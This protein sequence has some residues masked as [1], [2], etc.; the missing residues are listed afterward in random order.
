VVAETEA[1]SEAV[2]VAEAVAATLLGDEAVQE[3]AQ[4]VTLVSDSASEVLAN[5]SPPALWARYLSQ[6]ASHPIRTKCITAFYLYSFS[7][8]LTQMLLEK[9]P[10]RSYCGVWVG[11]ALPPQCSRRVTLR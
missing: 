1:V 11:V 5:A 2:A 4:T 3:M 6:L 10:V 9:K 8:T 7:D